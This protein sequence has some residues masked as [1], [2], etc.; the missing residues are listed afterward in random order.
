MSNTFYSSGRRYHRRCASLWWLYRRV[1]TWD[2]AQRDQDLQPRDWLQ[3]SDT[4]RRASLVQSALH[5]TTMTS[6]CLSSVCR[7]CM[8]TDAS[9]LQAERVARVSARAAPSVTERFFVTTSRASPSRRSVVW[10]AVAVSSVFQLVSSTVLS[11]SPATRT[12][13]PPPSDLRGD[14]RCS[15]VLPRGCHP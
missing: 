5:T 9:S 10:L 7:C 2:K 11:P 14:P 12:N 6:T 13:I 8:V 1:C 3:P 4:I 15:Q